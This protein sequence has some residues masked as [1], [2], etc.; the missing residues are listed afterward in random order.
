MIFDRQIP[1]PLLIVLLVALMAVAGYL[2]CRRVDKAGQ[3]EV[4]YPY[5]CR[6]TP[7]APGDRQDR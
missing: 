3:L 7:V 4:H 6:N 2:T 5:W 1:R